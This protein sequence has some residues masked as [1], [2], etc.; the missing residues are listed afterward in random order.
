MV[1]TIS[2]ACLRSVFPFDTPFYC[3]PVFSLFPFLL[4]NMSY[5]VTRDDLEKQMKEFIDGNDT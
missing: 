5:S 1:W 2:N 4:R 3:S